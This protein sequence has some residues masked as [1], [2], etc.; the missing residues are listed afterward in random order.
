MFLSSKMPYRYFLVLL[1]YRFMPDIQGWPWVAFGASRGECGCLFKARCLRLSTMPSRAELDALGKVRRP[2]AEFGRA[3]CMP[4]SGRGARYCRAKARCFMYSS[5]PWGRGLS[6]H[7]SS[8]PWAEWPSSMPFGIV[9]ETYF[10]R[11]GCLRQS[12]I[13]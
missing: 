3:P 9:R 11:V 13:P 6:I 8:L 5:M 7:Q 2:W 12:S 10:R 4:R 1:A